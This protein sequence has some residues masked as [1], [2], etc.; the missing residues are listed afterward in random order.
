MENSLLQDSSR[1]TG[2]QQ[3]RLPASSKADNVFLLQPAV[4]QQ[5]NKK[6]QQLQELQQL[7]LLK[8]L[9]QQPSQAEKLAK[10][11]QQLLLV[12]QQL[13]QQSQR[14]LLASL[15]PTLAAATATNPSF[16]PL[17]KQPVQP[18]QA[19]LQ[20]LSAAQVPAAS[21]AA[22]PLSAAARALPALQPK[23]TAL[24]S[25]AAALACTP[26]LQSAAS[27]FG[28]GAFPTAARL[29]PVG[30]EKKAKR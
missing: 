20:T 25:A 28:L 19:F 27:I 9:Y 1:L 10:E 4:L 24:A 26:D 7:Q 5:Q 29:A 21:A 22:A 8:Q 30:E 12:E 18:A 13:L 16:A 3:Q 15:N 6:L 23:P 14:T 11:K 2:Q 17:L